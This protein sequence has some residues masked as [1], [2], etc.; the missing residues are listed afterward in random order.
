MKLDQ[1]KHLNNIAGWIVFLIAATVYTL[2]MESTASLWDCGEFIASAQK[3]QVVHPPGAPL[4]L[5]IGRMFTFLAGGSPE[6]VSLS[7]NFMSALCSAT[8]MLFLFWIIT[9]MARRLLVGRGKELETGQVIAI[10]GAGFIGALAGTFCDS[11]WFSAVEAEVY[12]M[13]LMWTAMVFW[14]MLKWEERADEPE[15]DRWLL[16]IAF[17]MGCSIFVHWLNLLCIPAM[18]F[19]YYFRRHKPTYTGMAIVFAFSLFLIQY[20]LSG[21]IVGI[22][23]VGASLELMLVNGIGLPFNSGVIIFLLL[24]VGSLAMGIRATAKGGERATTLSLGGLLFFMALTLCISSSIFGKIVVFGLFAGVFFYLNSGNRVTSAGLHKA[25]LCIMFVLIGYSTIMTTVIRSNAGPNIDMNSPRDIVSLASYLKREQYGSRPLLTGYD[26][27]AQVADTRKIGTKWSKDEKKGKYLDVGDKIEYVFEGRKTLFPRLHSIEKSHRGLYEQWL[28]KKG[29]PNF[30]DNIKFFFRY[31]IGHMYVRYFMWNFVGRQNDD[32]GQADLKDGNWVSGVNFIDGP[33]LGSANLPKVDRENPSRNTYYFLPL[34]LGLLGLVFHIAN[35]KRRAWIVFL[36][37]IMCGVAIIVQGNSPPV[38]PRERDYI[39]AASFWAFTIWIGLGVIALYD[40]L[41]PMLK[42]NKQLAG[43]LATL[44]GLAIP[45]IMGFQNWDDHDRSDRFAARDFAANYLNS[46]APNSIIFTQ[47]DNDTYPLWYAQ[48]VEG[49]RR[50]V[51]VVNLSLL[52]VDW[53]IEQLRRKVND[54]DPV[55]MTMNYDKIRGSNRDLVPYIDANGSQDDPTISLAKMMEFIRSDQ[56]QSKAGPKGDIDFFPTKKIR[57]PAN[58]EKCISRGA[59]A[60]EDR[61]KMVDNLE[62]TLN[63]TSLYKNDLMTLDILL[64]NNWERPI[65]FAISVSPSSYL[66]L[67][68]YFQLEGLAYRIVPIQ[69]GRSNVSRGRINPDIMYENLM[70]R[71]TFGNIN[72]EGVHVDS[73]LS[74]MIFN[75]RNNYAR[76]AKALLKR[77]DKEK[78]VEVLQ[79]MEEVMPDSAAPYT[80]YMYSAVEAYYETG[81]YE[82][83]NKLAR[84]IA[85]RMVDDLNYY[86]SLPTKQRKAFSRDIRAVEDLMRVFIMT[87]REKGQTEFA[88]E[89]ESMYTGK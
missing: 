3:M 56:Q 80:L 51:R 2:T 42:E 10:L 52:G 48:E 33:R 77:G 43:I 19:I 6:L 75:F 20:I 88:S 13:S 58:K 41:K 25:L 65:Y 64:A 1:F 28:G 63:K 54:A 5:M 14:A 67:E 86:E 78:A 9:H 11:I 34:L 26:Y 79:R 69:A 18:A 73:D 74:R 31:Q 53:Y 44:I 62:W 36:L 39:F 35:D 30:F 70:N 17:L 32:Q 23:D 50:D 7:M 83:A 22:V 27:T 61:S 55:P 4:F 29:R 66:G 59:I 72:Q 57:F 82:K 49:I 16:F 84:T 15:G 60:P 37:F 40:L 71:F 8:A 38:E 47:G 89:L 85:G 45:A 87:A 24:L 21:V 46:C 68:K 76:L 12:S 81:D